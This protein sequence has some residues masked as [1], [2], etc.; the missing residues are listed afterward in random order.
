MIAALSDAGVEHFD[1]PLKTVW[2]RKVGVLADHRGAVTQTLVSGAPEGT[3]VRGYVGRRCV[4]SMRLLSSADHAALAT[5]DRIEVWRFYVVPENGL[6]LGERYAC[7]IEFWAIDE[8]RI[9]APLPN[10]VGT[11]LPL[12]LSSRLE[13]HHA[14]GAATLAPMARPLFDEVTFPIDVVYT[15]VDGS[16]PVW[17]ARKATALEGGVHHPDSDH[18][19]R[20]RD[21]DELRYSLRS[22]FRYMPW[23]RH[24]YLVTD[25]QRPSWLAREQDR[26]TVVDHSDILDPAILPTY[27]SHA[28]ETALHRIP[29]LSEQFLYFNDDVIVGRPLRPEKFFASNG[30]SRMF[31]SR[32]VIPAGPATI[33]DPPHLAA[34]RHTQRVLASLVGRE[35]NQLFKHTPHAFRRSVLEELHDHCRTRAPRDGRTPRA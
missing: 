23:V 14:T 1:I 5:V 18:A 10:R 32:A 4:L 29:G 28:I 25:Q 17:A 21:R 35:A 11:S 30:S 6:R 7:V 8:D 3:Y 15:W 26:V 9:V 27:N 31:L 34:R 19:S 33:D 16:D 22:I 20:F 13:P 2:T 12:A 24:I